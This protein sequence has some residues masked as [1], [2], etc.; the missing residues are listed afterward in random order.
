MKGG[1]TRRYH[2]Y[3]VPAG[4]VTPEWTGAAMKLVSGGSL[5][6]ASGC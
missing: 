2:I 4:A 6:P 1:M 5:A 3:M